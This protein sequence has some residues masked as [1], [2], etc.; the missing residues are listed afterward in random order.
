MRR[1]PKRKKSSKRNDQ[2]PRTADPYPPLALTKRPRTWSARYLGAGIA[3]LLALPFCVLFSVVT[4]RSALNLRNGAEAP[5][6]VL[7]VDRPASW[8]WGGIMVD[9]TTL[10]GDQVVTWI[11]DFPVRPVLKPG[12]RITVLYDRDDPSGNVVDRR[13]G[14]D[15]M[16]P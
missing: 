10:E 8:R 3:V 6:T 14:P 4:G 9:F 13:V 1:S 5:A 15:F 16:P 7:E 12:D 11:D 2:P